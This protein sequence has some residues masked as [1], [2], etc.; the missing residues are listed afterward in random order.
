VHVLSPP[1]RSD[2]RHEQALI[3]D[4]MGQCFVTQPPTPRCPVLCAWFLLTSP[5]RHSDVLRPRQVDDGIASDGKMLSLTQYPHR[6]SGGADSEGDGA[7]GK[8]DSSLTSAVCP[9]ILKVS[10]PTRRMF[11]P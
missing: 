2:H 8:F 10:I 11:M 4:Q 1:L 5:L 3:D 9:S 7:L 6:P